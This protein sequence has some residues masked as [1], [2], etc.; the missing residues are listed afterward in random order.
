MN[1]YNSVVLL[2][3]C[4]PTV[5]EYIEGLYHFLKGGQQNYV[6]EIIPLATSPRMLPPSSAVKNG[7]IS[8]MRIKNPSNIPT[9]QRIIPIF[10]LL[11]LRLCSFRNNLPQ[12]RREHRELFEIFLASAPPCL[13]GDCFYTPFLGLPAAS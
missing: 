10:V 5:L 9:F 4:P 1:I 7:R 3:L 8:S 2:L 11:R 13:C 12:R 6:G